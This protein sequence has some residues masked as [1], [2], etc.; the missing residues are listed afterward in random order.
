MLCQDGETPG[1]G[2]R[3]QTRR[4]R[5]HGDTE[6]VLEGAFVGRAFAF[7]KHR[8]NAGAGRFGRAK[9]LP[10]NSPCLLSPHAPCFAPQAEGKGER[11]DGAGAA[12]PGRPR[13]C[14]NPFFGAPLFNVR[15]A[16]FR[17]FNVDSK[18]SS[19]HSSPRSGIR[20]ILVTRAVQ[21]IVCPRFG[22]CGFQPRHMSKSMA[23]LKAAPPRSVS[24]VQPHCF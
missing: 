8:T 10:A 6:A 15:E 20:D 16:V 3:R 14:G 24:R 4:K 1:R 23:R 21:E 2:L 5:R 22:R 17:L 12:K 7:G 9:C 19:S 11:G 13:A 18:P